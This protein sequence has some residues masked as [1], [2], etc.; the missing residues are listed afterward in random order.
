MPMLAEPVQQQSFL[1][2]MFSSIGPV[3]LSVLCL[4]GLLLFFGGL[5]VVLATRRPGV[6]A[7]CLAF[8]PLPL[9]IGLIG[10]FHG[11]LESFA[12]IAASSTAPA[13]RDVAAG[14]AKLIADPLFA[15]CVTLPG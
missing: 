14:V 2:W 15:L 1:S 13:P 9:M 8:V 3:Y 10:M 7:A 11:A 6:I 4:L 5:I 12:V